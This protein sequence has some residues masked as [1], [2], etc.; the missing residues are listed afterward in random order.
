MQVVGAAPSP[1]PELGARM[2]QF[3]AIDDKG[4]MAWI[5]RIGDRL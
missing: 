2:E 4:D 1:A 3:F 5:R